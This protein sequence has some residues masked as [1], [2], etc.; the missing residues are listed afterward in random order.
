LD[1]NPSHS[2]DS[3]LPTNTLKSCVIVYSSS[4]NAQDREKYARFNVREYLVKP[5]SVDVI[6]FAM[7]KALKL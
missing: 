2:R 1:S 6:S 4:V 5:L 7:R 3:R